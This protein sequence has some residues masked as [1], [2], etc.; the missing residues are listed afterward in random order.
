MIDK[1]IKILTNPNDPNF[2][3]ALTIIVTLLVAFSGFLGFIFNKIINNSISKTT[4]ILIQSLVEVYLD[5]IKIRSESKEVN[6]ESIRIWVSEK[7]GSIL[8]ARSY[9][10]FKKFIKEL[11]EN[12]Y[13]EITLPDEN[14]YKVWVKHYD[15]I[16]KW[17]R[18]E[19]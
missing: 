11:K 18:I 16:P 7:G 3:S 10:V 12:G 19:W 2:W 14:S 8:T 1:L 15:G 17:K 4:K 6:N 13:K 9:L 5:W